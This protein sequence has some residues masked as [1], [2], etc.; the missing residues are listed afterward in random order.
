MTAKQLLV[1][2]LNLFGRDGKLWVG[3]CPDE[4]HKECV[5]TSLNRVYQYLGNPGLQ[6]FYSAMA[7]L[8]NNIPAGFKIGESRQD[9][10]LVRFNDDPNTTFADIKT[11]YNNAIKSLEEK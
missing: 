11:L 3:K 2:S 9:M 10:R 5:M 6:V 7:A 4:P 1:N 8:E